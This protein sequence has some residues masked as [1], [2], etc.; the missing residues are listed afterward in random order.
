V[1]EFCYFDG[2]DLRPHEGGPNRLRQEF[3]FP[4]GRRCRTF[5]DLAQ[6][7][8]DDWAVARDLL[9]K[10]IFDQFLMS[11]GR[12][13][14][15][16]VTQEAKNQ[17]DPDIALVRFI[18]ALPVTRSQAPRLDLNPR[19]FLLGNLTA[20]EGRQ[21]QVTISNQGQGVLQGT[22]KVSEGGQWLRLTGS[23]NG[24]CPLRIAKDQNISLQVDT[25]GM[26]AAQTYGG[27]LTVITNGGV[28]EV[29]VRM[30]LVAQPFPRPP[31]QGA[32]TP[33]EMAERM[34]SQPKAAVPL[35]ESGEIARWF[36]GNSWN[37]PV[38]GTPARGVAGIQQFFEAMGLSKPP[39]VMVAQ[40]EVRFSCTFPETQR[41]QVALHTQAKKWVYGYVE[42]D[43]PWLKVLTPHVAGPQHASIAFEVDSRLLPAGRCEGRL[44]IQANAGQNLA[45]RVGGEARGGPSARKPGFL[46]AVLA[47][48]VACFLLRLLLIPVADV[49]APGPAARSA[50]RSV[51]RPT[52]ADRLSQFSRDQAELR[53]ATKL[54]GKNEEAQKK[55]AG[56]QMELA[57]RIQTF[58]EKVKPASADKAG[59]ALRK[60]QEEAVKELEMGQPAK[61]VPFQEAAIKALGEV[62]ANLTS[63]LQ[64]AGGWLTLPWARILLG[65]GTLDANLFNSVDSA[66]VASADYRHYFLGSYIRLFVWWTWWVWGLLG[67]LVLWRRGGARDLL[68]GL[69]AGAAAGVAVSATLAC[70]VMVVEVLPHAMFQPEQ[71]GVG[72][73]MVWIFL[74][75]ITWTLFGLVLGLLCGL[76]SPVRRVVLEPVQKILARIFRIFGL[77]GLAST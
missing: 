11:N 49:L 14:L 27:K 1:A 13:D 58:M 29:P 25:K 37:Y 30:D 48:A 23:A 10:G 75:L 53:L 61:A 12:A 54:V 4:S 39:A 7:C 62:R 74:A 51:D 68:W 15:V 26:P 42:S 32:K 73:L 41:F 24:E 67:M 31:F 3:V 33:R 45:I 64:S 22:L 21:L 18:N 63:N 57:K 59:P 52:D 5:D 50:A 69:I 9:H 66:P 43:S 20:G 2:A 19:R 16:K 47:M 35:L 46:Q 40:P 71:A 6:G 76:L 72:S 28:V 77:K 70:A 34:R 56:K 60:A 65:S 36:A 38:R 44:K 8:Q 55:L 17:P